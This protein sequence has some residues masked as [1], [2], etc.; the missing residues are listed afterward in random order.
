MDVTTPAF[1]ATPITN[2]ATRG[3]SSRTVRTVALPKQRVLGAGPSRRVRAA[4]RRTSKPIRISRVAPQPVP[5]EQQPTPQVTPKQRQLESLG[6]ETAPPQSDAA[7]VQQKP[8]PSKQLDK[9]LQQKAYLDEQLEKHQ[10]E[11]MEKKRKQSTKQ[12]QKRVR[13]SPRNRAHIRQPTILKD[14]FQAY[15]DEI[16]R[17]DLLDQAEV[18]ALSLQIR[19][20]GEVETAQR[21]LERSL[22]RRPSVPE[23]SK[24]LGLSSK[25]IQKR[26]MMGTAAKNS[27]VAANLRLVTSVAR[28]IAASKSTSTAGLAVDDM[29]QEGSVGLI[30]AAEK[31]DLTR[32][33]RFSTYATW[34]V[35]AY[36]MRS[37]TTQ[38]RMIKVPATVVEEYARIRKEYSR[39]SAKGSFKPS[40]AEVAK[41]LGITPAKL[42]FVL[43]VVT[44]APASLDLN[45]DA[46]SDSRNPRSL[47]EIVEGEDNLEER[48]VEDFQRSELDTAL[49]NCLKPIER[50]V[51]RLRF[52]LDDGQ[53]RTLREVG[54]VLGMSKERVRQLVFRALPKLKTPEIQ[55]MLTDATTR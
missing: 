52:G 51:I 34:W 22:G 8:P 50:A 44:E 42:R 33:Y 25:D 16:S 12:A 31:Y 23:L 53:T 41:G 40:D 24:K 54:D 21:V 37:I 14:T 18:V 45:I 47:V 49:R 46:G 39:L 38:S 28:K 4:P 3:T 43:K 20:G 32:G 9:A 2:I 55:R 19:Q 48:L 17:E 15:M 6:V 10:Q 7:A 5:A 13:T 26:L 27:L 29:I 30:R 36:I 1:A 35:R 11:K